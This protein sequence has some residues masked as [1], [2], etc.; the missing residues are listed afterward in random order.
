MMHYNRPRH[1]SSWRLI[2]VLHSPVVVVATMLPP[3]GSYGPE[4]AQVVVG[5]MMIILTTMIIMGINESSKT[6]IIVTMLPG[7]A[8]KGIIITTT[9]TQERMAMMTTTPLKEIINC[10][11]WGW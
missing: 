2:N 11:R 7:M 4:E 1:N 3:H 9:T 6:G 10:I 8:I 5:E